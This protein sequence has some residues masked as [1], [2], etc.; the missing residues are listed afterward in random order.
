MARFGADRTQGGADPARRGELR[1]A[2]QHVGHLCRD[3]G[4]VAP[5]FRR[6]PRLPAGRLVVLGGRP[7]GGSPRRL[8]THAAADFFLTFREPAPVVTSPWARYPLSRPP[9]RPRMDLS[10]IEQFF[11]GGANLRRAV[12][13]LTPA[14]LKAKPGPGKWSIHENVI[15]LLDSDNIAIDRMKRILT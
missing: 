1:P 6:R 8:V 7:L 13:G 15:H 12:E 4:D 5:V 14:E 3:R 2:Q 9:R 10:L 11:V